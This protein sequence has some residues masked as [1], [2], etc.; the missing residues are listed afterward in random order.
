MTKKLLTP[1]LFLLLSMA[2]FGQINSFP[3]TESFDAVFTEGQDVM[4]IPNWTGNRV[5][6]T[7]TA[8]RIYREETDFNSAPAAISVIPTAAFTGNIV[9]DLDMTGINSLTVNFLA[10]SMANGTGTRTVDLNM[11]ASIDGGTSWIGSQQVLSLPNED[12]AVFAPFSYTLP[13]ATANQPAVIL[14]FIVSRGAGTGTPARLV[15]DDV[16][17]SE[18]TTTVLETDVTD[19]N[20][21]Q[22]QGTPS[23]AQII[24][25]S[26]GNL[27]GDVNI[28]VTADF[29]VSL[30]QDTGY[31]N[32]IVIAET[33]DFIG[34]IPVYTRLNA[35]AAGAHT[36]AVTVTSPGATQRTVGLTGN[37][38]AINVT[39]PTALVLTQGFNAAVF[40]EWDPASAM[41]TFPDHV[42]F[43]THSVSDPTLETPFTEDWHCL[44]N[45]TNRSRIMG[46]GENGVSFV[47]AANPQFVGVCDGSD[48][49]QT[50]GETIE[51]GKAGAVVLSLNTLGLDPGDDTNN[52]TVWIHW[53][54]RTIAQNNRIF[55]LRMQYRIGDGSANAN[56]GWTEFENTQE[57]VTG[58]TDSFEMKTT[59]L[60]LICDGHP[61]VQVRWVYYFISGTGNRAH[62]ALDNINI[63]VNTTLGISDLEGRK[64]FSFYPNPVNGNKIFFNTTSDITVS[65][66]SGKVIMKADNVSELYVGNLNPG[67]YF[68]CN[69]DGKVLKMVR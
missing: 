55:G 67:L 50:N 61:L 52:D 4:F 65:D 53:T 16:M 19:L 56:A 33:A 14:R 21:N 25:I 49:A 51:N 27:T 45:L 1:L 30:D 17:F 68:I 59:M 31:T 58:A 44:Y 22:L 8:T 38:V 64:S 66:V 43:W 32:V 24:N 20:F 35:T 34:P 15:M 69:N 13:L 7:A 29:E 18:S 28:S 42:A 36:G 12:Q 11:E 54:G 2:A 10:K 39:N 40:T 62:L 41:G 37:T 63:E 26:G 47:N 9:V 60:P 46:Q 57:Y 48:P 6:P 3:A 23:T 5:N